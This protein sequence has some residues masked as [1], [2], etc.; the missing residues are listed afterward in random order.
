LDEALQLAGTTSQ[1]QGDILILV[2]ASD[3]VPSE[4]APKVLLQDKAEN[5]TPEKAWYLLALATKTG[6]DAERYRTEL[7]KSVREKKD[8]I[9]NFDSL[10]HG[11]PALFEDALVGLPPVERGH[12]YAAAVIILGDKAPRLWR[13]NARRLL[14]PPE[15]PYFT[16]GSAGLSLR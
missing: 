6:R 10:A 8:L 12:A 15:R 5:L 11:K 1:V 3:S 9:H 7:E 4:L 2:A 16:L 14:F 13:E